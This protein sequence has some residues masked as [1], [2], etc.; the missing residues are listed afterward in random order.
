MLPLPEEII[1]V[2]SAFSPLFSQPVWRH[3][4][5]QLIGTVLS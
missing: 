1:A 3:V 5:V 4:Q 2:L